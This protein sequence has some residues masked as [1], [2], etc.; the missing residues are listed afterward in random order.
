MKDLK[1]RTK[2]QTAENCGSGRKAAHDG[3]PTS[4]VVFPAAPLAQSFPVL[5]IPSLQEATERTLKHMDA[6]A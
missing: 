2:W 4:P 6:E 3:F 5:R 1:R